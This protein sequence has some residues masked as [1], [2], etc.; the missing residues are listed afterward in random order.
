M[1]EYNSKEMSYQ[2]FDKADGGVI[3][4]KGMF[5]KISSINKDIFFARNERNTWQGKVKY[6]HPHGKG[7]IKQYDGMKPFFI[8][9][10][11]EIRKDT[12][13][14]IKNGTDFDKVDTSNVQGIRKANLT[15]HIVQ[16]GSSNKGGFV[17]HDF[18]GTIEVKMKDGTTKTFD[19]DYLNLVKIHYTKKH[20][21]RLWFRYDVSNPLPYKRETKLQISPRNA[22]DKYIE[23]KS[24]LDPHYDKSDDF[25][26][27]RQQSELRD[28]MS[29][30]WN[31]MTPQ[32][33]KK[34][35]K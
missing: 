17:T 25:R 34:A 13:N 1:K 3:I 21:K 24:Q 6:L 32:L 16:D 7:I 23:L 12:P 19:K 4:H 26:V 11:G 8:F 35:T 9:K 27:Y 33:R 2:D 28:E 22:Y 5:W 14:E 20:Y 18:G 29:K 10:D 31:L 15:N 30:M